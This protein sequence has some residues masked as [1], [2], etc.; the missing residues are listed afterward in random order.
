MCVMLMVQMQM[1]TGSRFSVVG[2]G[3][4]NMWRFSYVVM[5]SNYFDSDLNG[6]LNGIILSSIDKMAFHLSN[7]TCMGL[8]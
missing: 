5:L 3:G 2:T 8:Y 4:A 1:K 7:N 6:I